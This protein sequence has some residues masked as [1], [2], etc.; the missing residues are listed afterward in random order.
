MPEKNYLL[1]LVCDEFIA[2]K[3]LIFENKLLSALVLMIF[4]SGLYLIDPIPDRK[5][6]IAASGKDSAYSLIAKSQQTFLKNRGVDLDIQNT[7]STIRSAQLLAIP[8]SGVNA[9]FIQGGVLDDNLADQIQSLGSIAFEPVWIFYRADLDSRINRLKDLSKLRVGLGPKDGGTRVIAKKLFAL[10]D[11]NIDSVQNFKSDSYEGN[12]NDFLSG[13]LDVVINVNPE[14]DPVINR[15]L[16]EPSAKIF[17]LTHAAAYDKYLPFIRVVTLPAASINIADQIPPR[18]IA[19]LATTTNLA[20]S[21]EMHPSLQ[22]MLLMST[23]DAQRA[24]TSLFLSNEEKFPAYIDSS[25]PISEAALNFY[26]Y[27]VP[28]TMRHLPFWF[29]GFID[30]TWIYILSLLAIMYPLSY[31]NIN[32][33]KI[34]FRIYVEKIQR[35]L[36]SL[37]REL[38]DPSLG[39][40]MRDSMTVVLGDLFTSVSKHRI[41]VGCESDCL[42]LLDQINRL[43]EKVA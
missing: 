21:K 8:N 28:Q 24:T 11:I 39:G 34:R 41:P 2:I 38:L 4:I 35:E 1:T 13:S 40:Q 18:D 23:R 20:V 43:Q 37:E 9:A 14:I 22:V 6:L 42:D 25:I 17:E 16:H 26:D 12:L 27:G 19:L 29:A 10:N 15:L 7:Q 31:L 33:R 36:L 30:R 32:L 5:I 3:E